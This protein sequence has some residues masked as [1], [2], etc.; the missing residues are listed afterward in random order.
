[1]KIILLKVLVILLGFVLC[2][3]VQTPDERPHGRYQVVTAESFYLPGFPAD[4]TTATARFPRV[5]RIDTQ[6]GQT[7]SL[8]ATGKGDGNL[9]EHWQKITEGDPITLNS[10]AKNRFAD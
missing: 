1:M 4:S 7:W 9:Y 10:T 8:N 5:I 2:S 3:C 6:T